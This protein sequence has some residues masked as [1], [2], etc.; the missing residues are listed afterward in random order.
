[1]EINEKSKKPILPLRWTKKTEAW[2]ES[3]KIKYLLVIYEIHLS[4]DKNRV[5]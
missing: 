5:Q 2:M 3:G 4:T 1:M